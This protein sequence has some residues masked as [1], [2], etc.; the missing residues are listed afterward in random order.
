[1]RSPFSYGFPMFSYGFPKPQMLLG[2][3]VPAPAPPLESQQ[4]GGTTGVFFW[5]HHVPQPTI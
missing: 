4:V 3:N 2:L 1:M 5:D